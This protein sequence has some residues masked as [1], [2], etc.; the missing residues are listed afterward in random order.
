MAPRTP[1]R[2]K[3]VSAPLLGI[4]A[5]VVAA[6]AVVFLSQR[7]VVSPRA[8]ASVS[9]ANASAPPASAPEPDLAARLAPRAGPAPRPAPPAA[10]TPAASSRTQPSPSATA[11]P[12]RAT[13]VTPVNSHQRLT[14]DTGTFPD[15]ESARFECDRLAAA[16]GLDA[17]VIEEGSS[18]ERFRVVLG[19]FKTLDRAETSASILHDRGLLAE[20]RIVPLPPRHRRL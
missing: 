5:L 10:P 4:L 6:A 20:A 11:D 7:F 17:W 8:G 15:F 16:S 13:A 12:A 2:R 1:R 9:S 18:G 14:L 19:V 3:R